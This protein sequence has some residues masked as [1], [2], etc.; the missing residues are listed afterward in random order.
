MGLAC[1]LRKMSVFI[2]ERLY[3]EIVRAFLLVFMVAI[4][5]SII[6][7]LENERVGLVDREGTLLLAGHTN[8][9]LTVPVA[10]SGA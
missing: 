7:S 1:I 9:F 5:S 8:V 10:E 2:N 4:G 3:T 6:S